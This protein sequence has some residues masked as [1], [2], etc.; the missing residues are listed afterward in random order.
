MLRLES[1]IA[2]GYFKV[3]SLLIN[4]HTNFYNKL[5]R[6][7]CDCEVTTKFFRTAE[8]SSINNNNIKIG[9]HTQIHGIIQCFNK[10]A[11]VEIGEYCFLGPS[12]RLWAM[13]NIKIG[14]RCLI[15]HNVH[16]LDTNNHS[17]SAVKRHAEAVSVFANVHTAEYSSDVVTAPV[18]IEDDVWVGFGASILKGVKIGCGSIIGANSVVTKDVPSYSIIAGNPSKII[19]KSLP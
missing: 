8:I 1:Y 3:A 17:F 7:R 14:D 6:L 9:K 18:L 15:S 5:M 19:G 4:L 10:M 12:S 11:I 13:N 16:I 2:R